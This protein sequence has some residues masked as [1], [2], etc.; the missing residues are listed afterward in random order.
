MG[1]RQRGQTVQAVGKP[2]GDIPGDGC[3]P[4]MADE[5]HPLRAAG[6]DQREHIANQFG[7]AV[8]PP[9][10]RPSARRVSAL[11]RR[12]AAVS[13]CG[14][15][16]DDRPV[17]RV[18]LRKA[19]QK[20]DDRPVCGSGID[21]VEGEVATAELFHRLTISRCGHLVTLGSDE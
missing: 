10:L 21:H 2:L 13:L 15:P 20:D 3:T 4:V 6:I 9:P 8:V 7:I 16:V 12:K 19:V 14:Q 5:V 17:H 11:Q 18:A 1:Y